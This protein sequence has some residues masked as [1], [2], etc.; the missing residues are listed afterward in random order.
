VYALNESA[1]EDPQ[2]KETTTTGE[3]KPWHTNNH[4]IV[5]VLNSKKTDSEIC[6]DLFEESQE[7]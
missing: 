2:R 1:F 3:T 7:D 5:L 4:K 6:R